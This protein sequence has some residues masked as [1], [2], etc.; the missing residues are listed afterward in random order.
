M[1]PAKPLGGKTYGSIPHLPGSRM[2][3]GDH[4]CP[5][6]QERICT[7]RV[8]DVHDRIIVQEK[9]DGSN[10]GVARINGQIVALTRAGYLAQTSPYAQHH[11]FAD[12][13]AAHRDRFAAVLQ[14]GERLVGEWLFQAHSTRYDLVHEPFVAF[15]L[16]IGKVRATHAGMQERVAKRFVMPHVI[17]V[18]SALAVADAMQAL[19]EHGKH[20]ARDPI[21]GI[22]YRVE[23]NQ[24]VSGT[25]GNVRTWQV[26]FL[27][28]Y[29]RPEKVDGL[30]LEGVT[31]HPAV[32][33]TYPASDQRAIAEH[34]G[35]TEEDMHE[36]V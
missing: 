22:I 8:R 34:T 11:A 14:D 25:Q 29:V 28:K 20:G 4:H 13:V 7:V 2:G 32:W 9:L 21:E 6:G 1:T 31:G 17:H 36:P 27:A 26:D 24:I 16:M 35:H 12:W 30:Y 18:G 15:D 10:V 23:R 3:V 33:N 19:G 5:E